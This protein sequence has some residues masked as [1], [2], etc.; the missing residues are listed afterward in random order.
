MKKMI[1][2]KDREI[3]FLYHLEIYQYE[4]IW[5][6]LTHSFLKFGQFMQK[7]PLFCKELFSLYFVIKPSQ[8]CFQNKKFC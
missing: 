3:S 5:F 1:T 8:K 6:N 4:Q 7:W 2:I